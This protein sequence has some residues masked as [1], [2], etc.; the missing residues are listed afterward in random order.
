MAAITL[1][2]EQFDQ[3][4]VK[5]GSLRGKR[6]TEQ[7][8]NIQRVIHSDSFTTDDIMKLCENKTKKTRK[9]KV[10]KPVTLDD[11]D[12]PRFWDD[13]FIGYKIDY[14]IIDGKKYSQNLLGFTAR[15][16][17]V[18][19]KSAKAIWSFALDGE[20]FTHCEK[21]TIQYILVKY[22]CTKGAKQ[23]LKDKLAYYSQIDIE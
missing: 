11:S 17:G 21:Q 23:Y 12:H 13:D 20:K 9:S 1:T 4:L 5:I 15:C 8:E 7:V 3:L 10:E 16:G 2:I 19:L 18:N 14:T 22:I 6:L